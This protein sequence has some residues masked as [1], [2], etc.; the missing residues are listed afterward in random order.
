[1]V[2]VVRGE[3]F[4][5]VLVGHSRVSI[6]VDFPSVSYAVEQN[7]FALDVV[8]DAVVTYTDTPLADCNMAQFASLVRI[9]LEFFQHRKDPPMGFSIESA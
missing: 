6:T 3:G 1:V 5:F 7:L 2:G 4:A 9:V 8:A